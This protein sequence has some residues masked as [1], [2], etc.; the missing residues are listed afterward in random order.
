MGRR[1]DCGDSD[2]CCINRQARKNETDAREVLQVVSESASNTSSVIQDL[3]KDPWVI[4]GIG[5][6]VMIGLVYTLPLLHGADME[7]FSYHGTSLVWLAFVVAAIVSGLSR[8]KRRD[9]RRFWFFIAVAFLC[10]AT[11]ETVIAFDVVDSA[12]PAGGTF[13]DCIYFLYYFWWIYALEAEPHL[14]QE[15]RRMGRAREF[16]WAG[17]A[18]F[19]VGVYAY[20]VLMPGWFS[21]ETYSIWMPS[22]LFYIGL[23]LYIAVRVAIRW[24]RSRKPRWRFHYGLLAIGLIL[25]ATADIVF[26]VSRAGW[27]SLPTPGIADIRW[28]A[29]FLFIMVAARGR[30]L[31]FPPP[32]A[33]PDPQRDSYSKG[34]YLLAYAFAFP[35]I[36]FT[37]QSVGTASAELRSAREVFVLHWILVL[38]GLSFA[39]HRYIE[40]KNRRLE[41]QR[42]A[43]EAEIRELNAE[44]EKRVADRTAQLSAANRELEAFAYSVSHDLRAPLRSIDGFSRA[45]VDDCS[46]TLGSEGLSHLQ[47]VRRAAQ[48]MAHLI[49]GLLSLSLV[50]R[51]DMNLE[52]VDLS[53]M[54]LSVVADL[55]RSAPERQVDFEV[56]DSMVVGNADAH[57]L[58]VVLENLLGNAWKFT[59]MQPH[60]KIE[61]GTIVTGTDPVYFVRDNGIGF[62]MAHNEKLFGAFQR[63]HGSDE[64]EGDGIGLA[65]V[66]RIIHRHGGRI[67]AEGKVGEGATFFFAL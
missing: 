66:Q 22:F 33:A 58:H 51:R 8:V 56:A 13:L 29:P 24:S 43:S 53:S 11:G 5:L 14:N 32:A 61:V 20:F 55:Q 48:H 27:I 60:A 59:A 34:T 67:W 16:S 7:F 42:R 40:A 38:G 23:D 30:G 64:F 21:P 35:V 54:A 46:D 10:S 63:L 4:A 9:E 47:R 25:I 36:H 52:V 57:L 6:Y 26:A 2:I 45:L 41:T 3:A 49:D 17:R 19:A 15:Q 39:Q 31:S 44:L 18:L 37:L 65:T 28:F 1:A 50:T 12:D 62:A